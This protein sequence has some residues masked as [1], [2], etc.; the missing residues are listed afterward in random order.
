VR[1]TYCDQDGLLCG[2]TAAEPIFVRRQLAFWDVSMRFV[3]V[4]TA[5]VGKSTF[6]RALAT[7]VGCPHVEL[8]TLYW[9]PGWAA[10]S[11]D[12]FAEAVR[13]A[14]AGE[15]WVADGNYSVTRELLWSRAT[16]IV[17]LNFARSTVMSRVLARTIRRLLLR[18]PICNGNRESLRMA[19]LSRDSILLY[20]FTTFTRNRHKFAAL[21]DDPTYGH[22]QWVEFTESSAAMEYV[23]AQGDVATVPPAVV[24]A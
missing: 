19:F 16:H 24:G 9:G 17:W 6:A 3:V 14:T 1:P 20:A 23:R 4:G 15:R 13:A 10:T 22:L 21:R 5:G 2:R 8:D 12:A 18:T 7:A 11:A